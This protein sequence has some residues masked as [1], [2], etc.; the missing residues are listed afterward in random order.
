MPQLP[1][2]SNIYTEETED[3]VHIRIEGEGDFIPGHL[4]VMVRP[5]TEE[6]TMG[7]STGPE[8][9]GTS[10]GGRPEVMP[11]DMGFG[12]FMMNMQTGVICW[13]PSGTLQPDGSPDWVVV[14]DPL[15]SAGTGQDCTGDEDGHHGNENGWLT[16]TEEGAS[17]MAIWNNANSPFADREMV[18]EEEGTTNEIGLADESIMEGNMDLSAET[19]SAYSQ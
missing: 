12:H 14:S 17:S 5:A 19:D 15:T 11:I 6:E 13:C 9:S 18:I 7:E 3:G 1:S 8:D 2:I 16:A 4:T 10:E